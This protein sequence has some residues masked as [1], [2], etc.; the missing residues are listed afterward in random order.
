MRI[1]KN[2]QNLGIGL[3]NTYHPTPSL[4]NVKNSV[5]I[6]EMINRTEYTH[7]HIDC[8]QIMNLE[9]LCQLSYLF[10]K[11]LAQKDKDVKQ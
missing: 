8:I 10:K 4:L 3:D 2:I 11:I 1:T 6:S 9:Y 5:P 7:T